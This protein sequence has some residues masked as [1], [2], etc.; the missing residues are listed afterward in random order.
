MFVPFLHVLITYIFI[1]ISTF[2]LF[3]DY[4]FILYVIDFVKQIFENVDKWFYF[5]AII[6]D[7]V[8]MLNNQTKCHSYFLK[9]N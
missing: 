7:R 1:C 2:L 4:L 8:S 9:L 3:Q 5:V 6:F